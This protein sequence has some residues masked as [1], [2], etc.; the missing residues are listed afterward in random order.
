MRQKS[1]GLGAVAADINPNDTYQE[2]V[3][4]SARA[5]FEQLN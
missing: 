4:K 2:A 3:K 1:A 5:R